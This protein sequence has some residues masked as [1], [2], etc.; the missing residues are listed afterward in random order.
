MKRILIVFSL[1]SM[2]C[3]HYRPVALGSGKKSDV[4]VE[5]CERSI[6]GFPID[7]GRN[8]LA[9]TLS[10][11]GLDNSD[12]Y[13]VDHRDLLFFFPFYTKACTVLSLNTKGK[14]KFQKFKD[15][16]K[17]KFENYSKNGEK[18]DEKYFEE[19]E[20]DTPKSLKECDRLGHL[21]KQECR[22]KYFESKKDKKAKKKKR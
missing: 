10:A 15:E 12:I 14:K 19:I 17:S 20:V 16:Y 21:S 1:F 8:Q 18:S 4:E 7:N 9:K 13:S 5:S 3:S 11:G 22:K 6:I 2:G